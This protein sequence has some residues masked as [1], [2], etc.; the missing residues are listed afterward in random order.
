M[1]SLVEVTAKTCSKTL[2]KMSSSKLL[3]SMIN[4][5][6]DTQDTCKN[7][8]NWLQ[9]EVM[10]SPERTDPMEVVDKQLKSFYVVDL[11]CNDSALS[12]IQMIQ[13]FLVLFLFDAT[14]FQFPLE[15]FLKVPSS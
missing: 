7:S 11:P 8:S 3:R 5:N 6:L 14:S 13:A 2:K 4:I 12:Q 15:S 1:V 9:L 10:K